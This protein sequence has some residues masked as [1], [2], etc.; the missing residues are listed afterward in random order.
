MEISHVSNLAHLAFDR[1]ADEICCLDQTGRIHLA[2]AAMRNN[3]L[4]PG[5]HISE[6]NI[7]NFQFDLTA[8]QWAQIWDR[9][10]KEEEVKWLGL[11]LPLIGPP[12]PVEV[13][14]SLLDRADETIA[15]YQAKGHQS[16]VHLGD[17]KLSHDTEPSLQMSARSLF[18]EVFDNSPLGIILCSSKGEIVLANTSISQK[19]GFEASDLY[20]KDIFCLIHPHDQKAHQRLYLK[21]LKGELDHTESKRRYVKA[22]GSYFWSKTTERIVRDQQNVIEYSIIMI[23]DIS[24]EVEATIE[25][26]EQHASQRFIFDSLP[27]IFYHKDDKNN[28]INCNSMAARSMSMN[29]KELIGCNTIHI[30]PAQAE[31]YFRDDLVVI[32]TGEPLLGIIEKYQ[33]PTHSY[34]V[35]TDKIPYYE[36]DG[37]ITGVLVFS[38]DISDLKRTEEELMAQNLTLERYIESN[39]QLENFAFIASHDLKEPLRTISNFSQLLAKRYQDK[40]GEDGKEFIEFISNGAKKLNRMINDLLLY[41]RVNNMEH[42][43]EVLDPASIIAQIN[44][45]LGAQIAETKARFIIEKLPPFIIGS[46]SKL[47]QLCQNLVSNALKFNHPDRAPRIRLSCEDKEKFWLFAIEDNGR[48]IPPQFQDKIFNLFEKLH[49]GHDIPGSGIGLAVCKRIVEQHGGDMWLESIEGV[50]TTFYFTIPQK[51]A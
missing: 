46:E 37:S 28:I 8:K 25:Y 39:S 48:G 14:L 4:L 44:E 21:Q 38:V 49:N 19:L 47:I 1:L 5:S 36:Q 11:H 32:N 26:E 27:V 34:W 41:S 30:H 16:N 33:T 45:L 20:E 31:Q 15:L 2:N 6:Q 29:V 35:K 13:S 18:Q 7:L 43:E 24:S 3:L 17:W 40:L 50:G 23:E 12:Y 22:D 51:K 9:L 10:A 42:I